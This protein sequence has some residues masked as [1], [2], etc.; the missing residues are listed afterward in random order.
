MLMKLTKKEM[1][2]HRKELAKFCKENHT[3]MY[4]IMLQLKRFK[5]D[6]V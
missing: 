6:F 1:N 3:T 5:E 4:N 2:K